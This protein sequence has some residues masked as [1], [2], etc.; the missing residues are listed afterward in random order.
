MRSSLPSRLSL[1]PSPWI[2]LRLALIISPFW[3]VLMGFVCGDAAFLNSTFLL[4]ILVAIFFLPEKAKIYQNPPKWP[5]KAGYKSTRHI[6]CP[7][8]KRRHVM[9]MARHSALSSWKI[10]LDRLSIARGLV[11]FSLKLPSYIFMVILLK[12]KLLFHA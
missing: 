2:F 11:C 7:T 4:R 9:I 1:M 5:S 3:A 12:L 10:Q 6:S 8:R